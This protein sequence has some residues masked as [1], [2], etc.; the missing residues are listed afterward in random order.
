MNALLENSI[1]LS[2]F[3]YA[4]YL[5]QAS[6]LTNK[7]KLLVEILVRRFK[8]DLKKL[9]HTKTT[10]NLRGKIIPCKNVFVY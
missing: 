4:P 7:P 1:S 6:N 3:N 2:N 9:L 10:A 5:N 8:G